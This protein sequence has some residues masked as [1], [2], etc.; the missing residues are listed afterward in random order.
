MPIS[1]T[2]PSACGTS[3]ARVRAKIPRLQTQ[4][5]RCGSRWLVVQP[6]HE[7]SLQGGRRGRDLA[8]V[9]FLEHLLAG[10]AAGALPV[11]GEVLEGDPRRDFASVVPLGRIVRVPAVMSL[12]SPHDRSPFG[13]DCFATRSL[14]F[15][16]PRLQ[17]MR[18]NTYIGFVGHGVAGHY[19]PRL[20][21]QAQAMITGSRAA[22]VQSRSG[23][24][25]LPTRARSSRS[26]SQQVATVISAI[27]SPWVWPVHASVSRSQ[28]VGVEVEGRPCEVP[29]QVGTTRAVL[30]VVAV[31]MAAGVV[32]VREE[33]DDIGPRAGES[34]QTQTVLAHPLPVREAVDAVPVQPVL[35]S[36]CLYQ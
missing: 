2:R 7:R 28:P 5:V 26:A 4:C 10:T 17:W 36:D 3:A 23:R 33:F 19:R 18:L 24:G 16:V 27:V 1:S 25:V 35:G 11:L 21:L 15:D 6:S 8:A 29:G 32:E 34:S 30:R 14:C 12:A 9:D 31:V 20:L 13:E 22:S